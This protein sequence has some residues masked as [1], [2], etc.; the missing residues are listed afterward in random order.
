MDLGVLEK[1]VGE[2]GIYNIIAS[3]SKDSQR[4]WTVV[5]MF[6]HPNY[7]CPQIHHGE[8]PTMQDAMLKALRLVEDYRNWM[9]S[10]CMDKSTKG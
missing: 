8:G 5:L 10:I 4:R 7:S 3:V 6:D 1:T 9:E 2:L